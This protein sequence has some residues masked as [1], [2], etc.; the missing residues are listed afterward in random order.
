[1]R[2][3][4]PDLLFALR[5]NGQEP[6]EEIKLEA[7]ATLD[8][9]KAD[10]QFTAETFHFAPPE[11][12]EEV[13]SVLRPGRSHQSS[14]LLGKQAPEFVAKGLD[15]EPVRLADRKGKDV[16]VIDFWATWC[17][18]CVEL[19]P[20]VTA[21]T[22]EYKAKG[23]TFLAVNVGE[24]VDTVREFLKENKLETPVVFDFEG[25]IAGRYSGD[26]EPT[27]LPLTVLVGKDGTVQAVHVGLSVDENIEKR[28]SG[29]LD[30]LLA[31]KKLTEKQAKP[32]PGDG[33]RPMIP[34]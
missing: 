25:E 19:L 26:G 21:V 13:E 32:D 14:A 28:L 24:D 27:V 34:K 17:K 30:T 11:G 1:V 6:P 33:D 4:S 12:A 8:H 7:V 22:A 23:V 3:I 29:E 18:P 2:K 20:K 9:W 10:P 31:G 5:Q 15:G 16:I